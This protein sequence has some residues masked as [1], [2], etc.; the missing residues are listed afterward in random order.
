MQVCND[1]DCVGDEECIAVQDLIIAVDGSG[2]LRA[3]GFAIL[4]DFVAKTVERYRTQY[5]G[6]AAV[7]IGVVQFGNG[8][9]EKDGTISAAVNVQPMTDDLGAVKKAVEGLQW[10]KGFTNMAQAFT[11]AET[12]LTAGGRRDAQSAILVVTDGKPS[13]LFKTTQKIQQIKDKGS[14]VLFTTI[15]RFPGKDLNVFK[16]WASQPWE[17]NLLHVPGLMPLKA[18]MDVFAQKTIAKFCPNAR[19][20]SASSEEEDFQHYFLLKENGRCGDQGKLLSEKVVTVEECATLARDSLGPDGGYAAFS[21]G[22]RNRDGHCYAN[23][24]AVDAAKVTAWKAERANPS[25]PGGKWADEPFF[26]MFV[27]EPLDLLVEEKK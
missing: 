1:H 20:P 7:K 11:L 8:K 19:S 2:S 3:E 10:Q 27:L 14:K 15:S 5:F 21:V 13:F 16:K 23:A 24:M 17:T 26:D 4:R 22:T 9:V 12:M 25:C 6:A 18:D